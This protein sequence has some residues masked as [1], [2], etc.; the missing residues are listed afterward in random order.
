MLSRSIQNDWYKVKFF[1]NVLVFHL[2]FVIILLNMEHMLNVHQFEIAS[3]TIHLQVRDEDGNP[4]FEIVPGDVERFFRTDDVS[5]TVCP[6]AVW[7]F[8]RLDFLVEFA[9]EDE[10]LAMTM[11]ANSSTRLREEDVVMIAAPPPVQKILQYERVKY[12]YRR[13]GIYERFTDEPGA[14]PQDV[15]NPTHRE[16]TPYQLFDLSRTRQGVKTPEPVVPDGGGD[17]H[18]PSSTPVRDGQARPPVQP[19]DGTGLRSGNFMYDPAT[20]RRTMREMP[21]E[22]LVEFKH[23]VDQECV[24]FPDET[25][26]KTIPEPDTVEGI[27]PPVSK[28]TREKP[29][30]NT[31]PKKTDKSPDEAGGLDHE[32]TMLEKT[33]MSKK[34]RTEIPRF[35]NFSGLIGPKES[36]YDQWA[37]K[38][39]QARQNYPEYAVREAMSRS[40]KGTVADA[41][42]FLGDGTS[43]DDILAKLEDMYGTV[44][45]R[46]VLMTDFYKIK[47]GPGELVAVFCNKIEGSLNKICMRCPGKIT[48]EEIKTHL[49][50]R[51]FNGMKY[52]L[53]VGVRHCYEQEDTTY[54]TLMGEARK[55]EA[56]LAL[57]DFA[58]LKKPE[59][60]ESKKPAKAKAAFAK[61]EAGNTDSARGR[62]TTRGNRWG[63]NTRGRGRGRGESS[64]PR[65]DQPTETVVVIEEEVEPKKSSA[66]IRAGIICWT[67]GGRGHYK[68]ECPSEPSLN[69]KGTDEEKSAPPSK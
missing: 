20:W 67:C 53:R 68:P 65:K 63:R 13:K 32:L 64:G 57:E 41:V 55:V 38:V 47:Q 7:Q 59:K 51:L 6:L 10:A 60:E 46:D 16:W 15:T 28:T 45:S 43:I 29:K 69:S 33:L 19:T 54:S 14:D 52:D 36:S 56:E 2:W 1:M 30:F 58:E 31:E 26:Y 27:F 3:R 24:F 34:W 8:T 39:S 49:K 23:V 44:G 66:Q 18:H 25:D 4:L 17:G 21:P 22:V 12:G 9:S 42:R 62:G 50:D 40:M 5:P 37:Y 61:V 11:K 48:P 35:D